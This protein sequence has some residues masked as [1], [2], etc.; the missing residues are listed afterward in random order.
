MTRCDHCGGEVGA[1]Q[2]S[3]LVVVGGGSRTGDLR[4][5]ALMRTAFSIYHELCY[6]EHNVPLAE[7]AHRR[8]LDDDFTL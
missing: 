3:M 2:H 5:A 4:S 6:T 8:P 1:D 7:L